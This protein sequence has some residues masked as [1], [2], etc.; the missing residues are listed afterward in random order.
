MID[1]L[2]LDGGI[3]ARGGVIVTRE[4]EA[5]RPSWIIRPSRSACA[6]RREGFCADLWD[7]K[8]GVV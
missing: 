3:E 6:A 4:V 2:M 1:K 7:L 8:V 5:E